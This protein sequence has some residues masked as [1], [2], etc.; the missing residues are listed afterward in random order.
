MELFIIIG[1]VL[2]LAIVGYWC[3]L[4]K[5]DKLDFQEKLIKEQQIIIEQ[6][7]EKKDALDAEILYKKDLK[8]ELEEEI[9]YKRNLRDEIENNYNVISEEYQNILVDFNVKKTNLEND[10][11]NES[12]KEIENLKKIYYNIQQELY[13]KKTSAEKDI[14]SLNEDINKLK[15]EQ[16]IIINRR[17]QEEQENN[18][19]EDYKLQ[20]N[21]QQ[22]NDLKVLREVEH[23]ISDKDSINKL[24]WKCSYEK[25]FNNLIT[26]ILKPSAN[27][28]I[29]IYK[30]TNLD[31]GKSYIGQSVDLKERLR[32]HIKTGVGIDFKN[33]L[34]YNEMRKTDLTNF[35][36]EIIEY[37]SRDELN[38]KEKFWIDYYLTNQYGLNMTK[39]GSSNC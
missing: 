32:T 11:K 35:T 1:V 37:C 2:L 26:R 27:K 20:L 24:I 9:L 25:P 4:Q 38:D 28:L 12:Q 22:L 17:I 7:N 30:I 39:G 3:F 36:F 31:N 19:I 6:F 15:E 33:N 10:L 29:G 21:E 23:K 16:Q 13:N 18:K 5:K 34:L 14:Y 8:K